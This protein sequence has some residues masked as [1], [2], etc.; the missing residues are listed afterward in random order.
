PLLGYHVIAV[1]HEADERASDE[2]R[3]E[4]IA[5]PCRKQSAKVEADACGRDVRRPEVHRLFH[6][7]L[8]RLV[9]VDRL[10]GILAAVADHRKAVVLGFLDEIDLVADAR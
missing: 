3:D 8:R 2:R 1:E 9:A 10:A 6:P 7:G 4:Q 5:L